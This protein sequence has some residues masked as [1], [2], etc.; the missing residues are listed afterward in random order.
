MCLIAGWTVL[1]PRLR[2]GG[3]GLLRPLLQP[4]KCPYPSQAAVS[5]HVCCQV[6]PPCMHT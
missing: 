4:A 3:R 2:P 5:P 1:W 6:C